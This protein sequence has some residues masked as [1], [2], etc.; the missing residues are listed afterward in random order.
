MTTKLEQ[1]G[2]PTRANTKFMPWWKKLNKELQSLGQADANF[3]EAH[4]CFETGHA[5][6]TAAAEI[7][8]LR[9]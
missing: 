1:Y 7:A 2:V 4:D 8:V 5:P 9:S 3:G 6:S